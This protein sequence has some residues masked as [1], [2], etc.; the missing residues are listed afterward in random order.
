MW[1]DMKRNKRAEGFIKIDVNLGWGDQL[2]WLP[3]QDLI[4]SSIMIVGFFLISVI[5][6]MFAISPKF[7]S[8]HIYLC[9]HVYMHEHEH[10][11]HMTRIAFMQSVSQPHNGL[12]K[13][14]H[15]QV[16]VNLK[17][18]M[19]KYKFAGCNF[20]LRKREKGGST[21]PLE[22]KW[23]FSLII[24]QKE[25]RNGTFFFIRGRGAPQ[26]VPPISIELMNSMT[27]RS[28][29]AG[30]H[31]SRSIRRLGARKDKTPR[32]CV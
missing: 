8:K 14:K 17:N 16:K 24:S 27:T 12:V 25:G 21:S 9:M 15:W 23:E 3:D 2:L 4:L 22:K 10:I 7:T 13:V 32:W 20:P 29:V 1:C 5:T 31:G 28:I 18:K 6:R 19:K 30:V 11:A 26:P